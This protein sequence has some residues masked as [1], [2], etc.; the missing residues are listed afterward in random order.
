MEYTYSDFSLSFVKHPFTKD[1]LMKYDVD[2]AKQALTVLLLTN[3]YEKK[4]DSKF[5]V[6]ISSMLFD[7]M[8]PITKIS[9]LKRIRNQ[10]AFYEP[11][12]A[13]RDIQILDTA[14]DNSVTIDFY[15]SILDNPNNVETLT[16]SFNRIR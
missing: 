4:F 8:T 14:D 3:Q 2:S 6:G 9:L 1:I 11:R 12:I 15:F 7:L 10:C 16:L 13:I 5:G